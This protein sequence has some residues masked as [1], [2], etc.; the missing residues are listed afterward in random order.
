MLTLLTPV[1]SSVVIKRLKV[2][3]AEATAALKEG[4]AIMD[5]VA[6]L[7]ADGR[8]FLLATDQ[9]TYIGKLG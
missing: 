4:E 8:K 7:L 1:L 3:P 9:P 2:G 6:A 5:E